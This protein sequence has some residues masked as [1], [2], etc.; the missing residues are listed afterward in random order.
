MEI[1][2]APCVN[3]FVSQ[4]FSLRGALVSFLRTFLWPLVISQKLLRPIFSLVDVVEIG[5]C[6]SEP[7]RHEYNQRP[8]GSGNMAPR[9]CICHGCAQH[10]INYH[11]ALAKPRHYP[12]ASFLAAIP[13]SRSLQYQISSRADLPQ[14]RRVFFRRLKMTLF[15]LRICSD[16]INQ[17]LLLVAHGSSKAACQCQILTP[18]I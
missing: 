9:V 13:S 2:L 1:F 5:I 8:T 7:R 12:I 4:Y 11:H 10:Y 16:I 15:L 6:L 14:L 18:D 3:S 17:C